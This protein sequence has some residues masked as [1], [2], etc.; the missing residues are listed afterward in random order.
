MVTLCQGRH[1]ADRDIQS[2]TT[3]NPPPRGDDL[4]SSTKEDE[5]NDEADPTKLWCDVA[6]LGSATLY[7]HLE[8]SES[9]STPTRRAIEEAQEMLRCTCEYA[10]TA[11]LTTWTV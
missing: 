2:S 4:R 3:S 11:T 6:A 1:E 5:N 8:T 9:N 7:A 10:P